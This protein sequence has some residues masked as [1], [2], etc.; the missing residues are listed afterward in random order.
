MF[1]W[2]ISNHATLDGQGGL[3]ASARWH[4]EGR[5]IVYLAESPPGAL[6]EHLVHLELNPAHLPK[7]CRLLKSE[8]P[9]D[10]P[11]T[12]L[13][14]TDLPANWISNQVA[15]RTAGDEWLAT[16]SGVLLRVPSAILPETFNM[17]LNPEHADASR[18]RV[19]WHAEHPW[20]ARLLSR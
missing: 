18:I 15:T 10:L 20:N 5:P 7:F 12:A 13:A 6:V 19:L 17:L 1:L 3:I 11:I 4:T 14:A 9:D 2:R 16:R 8:A